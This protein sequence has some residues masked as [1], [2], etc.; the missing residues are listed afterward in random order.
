MESVTLTMSETGLENLKLAAEHLRQGAE[1][2]A[3]AHDLFIKLRE[4]GDLSMR[5]DVPLGEDDLKPAAAAV[6]LAADG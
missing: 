5:A 3:A 4:L 2:Y 6:V 1:H